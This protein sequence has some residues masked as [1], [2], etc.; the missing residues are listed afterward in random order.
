MPILSIEGK[1]YEAKLTFAFAKL[2]DKRY[3]LVQKNDE[4][5]KA[6][7]VTG[8]LENIYQHLMNYD[9]NGLLAFW[10]CALEI[11]NRKK[12]KPSLEQI[13]DALSA[14]LESGEDERLF[15]E[16]FAA[17]E[18]SGFF[19]LKIK[20]YWKNLDLVDKLAKNEEERKQS[21]MAKEMFTA[22]R[23]ELLA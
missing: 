18:N 14:V 22:K 8:G 17:I 13:E 1:D 3:K 23:E 15:K 20:D 11:Y 5:G 9:A 4:K 21:R 2:A 7:L 19:R 12:A 16:A 10:D 6:D